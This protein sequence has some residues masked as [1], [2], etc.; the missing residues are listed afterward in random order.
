MVVTLI[1]AMIVLSIF[2][3]AIAITDPGENAGQMRQLNRSQWEAQRQIREI[4]ERTRAAIRAEALR[5]RQQ[6][7]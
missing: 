3:C 5:R 7:E 6:G 2:I 4:G 1:I